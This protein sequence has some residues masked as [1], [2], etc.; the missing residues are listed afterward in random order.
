MKLNDFHV[1]NASAPV[2]SSGQLDSTGKPGGDQYIIV[3]RDALAIDATVFIGCH[4]EAE[5]EVRSAA[6]LTD[7]ETVA[8]WTTLTM[9]AGGKTRINLPGTG[10]PVHV[11]TKITPLSG[12]IFCGVVSFAEFNTYFKQVEVDNS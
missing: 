9:P 7:L 11:V 2:I 12:R 4:Q 8:P 10:N 3:H 1:F 5:V 6:N